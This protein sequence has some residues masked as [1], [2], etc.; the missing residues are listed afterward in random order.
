MFILASSPMRV[1]LIGGGTDLPAYQNAGYTGMILS[2]AI[3]YRVSVSISE[4][5]DNHWVI[6]YSRLEKVRDIVEIEHNI[7]RE[8]LVYYGLSDPLEVHVISDISTVGTGLGG[9]SAL[10]C[11]LVKALRK[12]KG[13]NSLPKRVLQDAKEI[14]IDRVG[15]P[16]GL[17]DFIPAAHGGLNYI[18]IKNGICE[19]IDR[20]YAN[21]F[22]ELVKSHLLL[23]SET[24]NAQMR[25]HY[26]DQNLEG[27]LNLDALKQSADL[28]LKYAMIINKPNLSPKE[29]IELIQQSHALKEENQVNRS[30]EEQRQFLK[31][32]DSC[33]AAAYRRCGAGNHGF[34]LVYAKN[35]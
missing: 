11:A 6:Q 5:F 22:R 28:A 25:S 7:I 10:T 2:F 31:K 21:V 15:A 32:L 34:Y 27:Q 8:A 4:R 13:R 35:K 20:S 12:Y 14:E 9:S 17:Q 19:K 23:V 1:S 3:P 24:N 29:V 33:G 18:V 30:T 26:V 16:I